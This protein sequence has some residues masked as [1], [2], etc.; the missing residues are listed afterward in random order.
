MRRF[1]VTL[2]LVGPASLLGSGALADNAPDPDKPV[3]FEDASQVANEID[4]DLAK[5]RS[6]LEAV[7]KHYDATPPSTAGRVERRLKEGEIDYLLGDY[8]RASIVLLDVV[9]DGSA[10]SH[11]RYDDCV[12]LLADSL[13]RSKNYVGAKARFEELLQRARGERLKDVVLALLQIASAT[14]HYEDVERYIGRL[15]D[16]GTLSR[17]DVDYIYAKM[18]FRG[19]GN[20][21]A[22]VARAMELFRGIPASASVGAQASYYAGVCLVKLGRIDDALRQFSETIPRIPQGKDGAQLRELT[23]LSLG[24]L[25]QE[26]GD[27][28][29]SADAYQQIPQNSPYFG[30]TLYEI[31]WTHVKAANLATDPERKKQG[32]VNGLRAIELLIATA[33][34]SRLYPQARILEGNLQIR[35]GASETAYD[36]FQAIID[37]YGG[38]SDKLDEVLKQ[39]ADPKEFFDQLMAQDLGHVGGTNILPPVAVSWARDE[40]EMARAV[41]MNQDLETS[42]KDLGE[43]KELVRTLNSALDGEGRFVMFPGM[44]EARSKATAVENRLLNVNRRLLNLERRLVWSGLRPEERVAVDALHQKLLALESEIANLPLTEQAITERGREI[45]NQYREAGQH[46]YRLTYRVAGMRAEIVAVEHWLNESR[47]HLS[48]KVV[49]LIESRVQESQRELSQLDRDLELVQSDIR[50]AEAVY[51]VDAGRARARNLRNQYG[52]LVAQE[53]ALLR[54]YRDRIAPQLIGITTRIDQQRVTMGSIDQDVQQLQGMLEQQVQARVDEV[55]ASLAVEAQ[56]LG[57]YEGEFGDLASTTDQILGPVATKTLGE[58]EK[59][60]K[61]LVLQADVGIIDVAWARK[62][63]ETKKVNDL[64]KEQQDRTLEL[65]SEFADVLEEQ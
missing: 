22:K 53:S 9:E 8:F 27:E 41:S 57:Q 18:L 47:E 65:E 40:Q 4:I 37:R 62:Q 45:R 28:T 17:P 61:D 64:I 42:R 54:G 49:S 36:T 52:E 63:A 32:F 1:P 6:D 11:P 60:F 12:Y 50:T 23:Y 43:S 48:P 20:D 5:M 24:R 34:D 3:T 15:R 46:A 31:A 2:L 35:L 51:S 56:H 14:D 59:Q 29:K 16:A 44:R 26:L 39:N 30:E 21:A 10:K 33:P 25:Y 55:R 13:R 38:A 7:G 19:A 58:V